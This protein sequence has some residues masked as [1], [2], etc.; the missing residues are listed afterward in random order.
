MLT[1]R[2]ST[3]LDRIIDGRNVSMSTQPDEIST[4]EEQDILI[5]WINTISLHLKNS[6]RITTYILS[7]K[8]AL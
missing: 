5:S 3:N 4:F 2:G 1:R 7:N 8:K 6:Y